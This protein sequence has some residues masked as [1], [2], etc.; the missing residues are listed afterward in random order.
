MAKSNADIIFEYVEGAGFASSAEIEAYMQEVNNTDS[1][2]TRATI[3]RLKRAGR[4]TQ[5]ED[6]G[7]YR[8]VMDQEERNEAKRNVTDNVQLPI[9]EGSVGA[10]G[11][12]VMEPPSHYVTMPRDFL[13][14]MTGGIHIPNGDGFVTKVRGTSML[15]TLRDGQDVIV[16]RC[17]FVV[18]GGIY[19]FWQGD[20][21]LDVVKR[22]EKPGDGTLRIIADNEAFP[23]YTLRHI[24]E[25]M[26]EDLASGRTWH[27]RIRGV[28][29]FPE[30]TMHIR[31]QSEG[32]AARIASDT[33]HHMMQ[34]SFSGSRQA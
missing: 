26:Y 10:G 34:K 13:T 5:D 27:L 25:D 24:E 21:D 31:K 4:I 22:I 33:I 7:P 28:V 2:T 1:G 16:Q 18:M 9:Y 12:R 30:D 20:D 29:R 15:P 23:S 6:R 8:V 3:H 17:D 32:V 11:G 19:V 14:R